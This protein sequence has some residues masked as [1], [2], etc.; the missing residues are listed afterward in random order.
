MYPTSQTFKRWASHATVADLGEVLSICI[1]EMR[2]RLGP[3]DFRH[4]LEVAGAPL[5]E[6]AI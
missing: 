6:G 2:E 3:A 5:D 1:Q 4:E